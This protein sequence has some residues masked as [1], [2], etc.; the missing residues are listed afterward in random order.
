[1][2]AVASKGAVRSADGTTTA[3][4]AVRRDAVRGT[5]RAL[6]A[7]TAGALLVGAG[8]AAVGV[9]PAEAAA[10]VTVVNEL[11]SAQVDTTYSTP[12]TVSGTGF[13][14]VQG[15]F[16]GIYV[17]FGWVDDPAGG[18]WAPSR[19]APSASS[20]MA[21]DRAARFPPGRWSIRCVR[22]SRPGTRR[23]C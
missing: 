11:G 4:G 18:S 17:F 22:R 20:R 21:A 10:R 14:S 7:W 1:M 19:G 3:G 23:S 12:I 15:G 2:S 8:V 6:G 16:G 13:Q 9:A 5:T